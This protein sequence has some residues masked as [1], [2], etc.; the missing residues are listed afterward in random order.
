AVLSIKPVV[1]VGLISYSL[2]LWHQPILV[3]SKYQSLIESSQ[4]A[5]LLSIVLTA[6]LSLMTWQFIEQPFRNK[7]QVGLLALS[8]LSV[9]FIIFF[10]ASGLWVQS[11]FDKFESIWLS[12]QQPHVA[13]TYKLITSPTSRARLTRDKHTS[14]GC[15]FNFSRL[16]PDLQKKLLDCREKLGKGTLI[17]GDSHARGLFGVVT[18][19]FANPFLV[20]AIQGGCRPHTPVPQCQ[21]DGILKFVSEHDGVFDHVIYEQ[22]GFYLLLRKG[23]GKGNRLMFRRLGYREEVTGLTIDRE[24]VALTVGFL[25]KLSKYVPVTWFGP[26]LEPHI[27][28][29]QI[30]RRGCD[31]NYSIRTGTREVF[32]NLDSHIRS[33]L[34]TMDT[35]T[36]RFVSQNEAFEFLF[37]NDF[38]NCSQI[39]WSDGDH[40]SAD[41][42]RRFGGRLSDDFLEFESSHK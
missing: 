9:G 10:V 30:L 13:K 24:H 5:T 35:S 29:H 21:Y 22:A 27:A 36:V 14:T 12:R 38:M 41:G 11:R 37:P 19:R 8:S 28:D 33:S 26:R 15:R 2:Y 31:F 40:L 32:D 6:V 1:F 7:G 16:T 25:N 3:F 4:L 42:Q 17:L 34:N 23:G 39:Y 20:G 18:S